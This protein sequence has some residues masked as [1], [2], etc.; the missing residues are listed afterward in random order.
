MSSGG[1]GVRFREHLGVSQPNKAKKKKSRRPVDFEDISGFLY[2]T[3]E[4][5]NHDTYLL[6]VPF[7]TTDPRAYY[8]KYRR[9]AGYRLVLHLPQLHL[10]SYLPRGLE[11]IV[12]S[13]QM[14]WPVE[15]CKGC[16]PYFKRV[17]EKTFYTCL[18]LL[19]RDPKQ[20]TPDDV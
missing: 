16:Y 6:V 19:E 13:S 5:I 9:P 17:S 14:L 7:G 20:F 18:S 3:P 12:V 8:H 10:L 11:I 4:R 1:E 2:S 15:S